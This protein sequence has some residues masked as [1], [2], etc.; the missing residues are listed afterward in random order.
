MTS[1]EHRYGVTVLAVGGVFAPNDVGDV[2][3]G[4]LLAAAAVTMDLV[5]VRVSRS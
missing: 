1:V 4:V 5:A 2:A 3:F